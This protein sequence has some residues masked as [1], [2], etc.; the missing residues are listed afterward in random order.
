VLLRFQ[1]GFGAEQI[2][3]M[4]P[5]MGSA[6]ASTVEDAERVDLSWCPAASL[7]ASGSEPD[8]FHD[9]FA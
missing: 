8:H 7:G 6:S 1:H 5:A 2:E 9:S 4:A 3:E